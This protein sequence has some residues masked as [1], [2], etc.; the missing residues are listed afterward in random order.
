ML[1]ISHILNLQVLLVIFLVVLI[2]EVAQH[3][4]QAPFASQYFRFNL[5]NNPYANIKKSQPILFSCSCKNVLSTI[6]NI[7]SSTRFSTTMM[8]QK[9]P[10]LRINP[11]R[12]EITFLAHKNSLNA[13]LVLLVFQLF[14]LAF[15]VFS[16]VQ[17][18]I[19]AKSI[20]Y[21]T[22]D[23]TPLQVFYG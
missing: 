8:F 17:K 23:F 5:L 22:L 20:K 16:L 2:N 11:H 9:Q 13:F 7:G 4:H 12:I 10:L 1:N 15:Q 21:P 18:N 19:V 3:I 6:N 14:S